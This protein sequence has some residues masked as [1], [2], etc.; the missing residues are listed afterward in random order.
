M[1]RHH[2]YDRI[3]TG[4]QVWPQKIVELLLAKRADVNAKDNNGKTALMWASQN[5][6]QKVRELLIRAGAK[7]TP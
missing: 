2:L 4:L 7:I 6:Q 1:D 5:G 3:N